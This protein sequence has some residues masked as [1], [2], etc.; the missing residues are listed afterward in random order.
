MKGIA[1]LAG[2]FFMECLGL[3][4]GTINFANGGAGVNAPVYYYGGPRLAS[5]ANGNWLAMLYAGPAGTPWY[6]LSSTIVSGSSV[7]FSA[8]NPGYI[9]G[10]A[11]TIAGVPSGS[12]AT[13]QIRVWRAEHGATWEEAWRYAEFNTTFNM[14]FIIGGA[15]PPITVT[16]GG[17]PSPTPNMVGLGAFSITEFYMPEPPLRSV[18]CACLFAWG[19]VRRFG[20]RKHGVDRNVTGSVRL[21]YSGN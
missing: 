18:V 2:L 3:C 19:V 20:R 21:P 6:E 17:G 12:A 15:S 14:P 5:P 9:F 7:T 8:S 16:L 10:G 4:Q 1:L 13:L 11:R